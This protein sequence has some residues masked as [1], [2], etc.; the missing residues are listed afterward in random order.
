LGRQLHCRAGIA[1]KTAVAVQLPPQHEKR[2]RDEPWTL[3][4]ASRGRQG[5]LTIGPAGFIEGDPGPHRI[6]QG[7]A[8]G[9]PL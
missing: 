7:V 2:Q 9:S 8:K 4:L 6:G 1:R 5:P 3:P